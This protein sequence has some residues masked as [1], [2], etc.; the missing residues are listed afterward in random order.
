M[1]ALLKWQPDVVVNCAALSVPRVC[2][3]DP[4]SAMSTNVPSTL[5]NWFSCFNESKILLIHLST[6]QGIGVFI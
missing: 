2:E 4:D 6:D 5:V 1:I 3:N